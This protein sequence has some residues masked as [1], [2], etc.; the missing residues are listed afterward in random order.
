V[1]F[2]VRRDGI[3]SWVKRKSGPATRTIDDVEALKKLEE[4]NPAI[5]VAYKA[6]VGDH[7][8]LYGKVSF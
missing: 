6:E 3:V 1:P 8:L 7:A 5:V 4:E 2:A